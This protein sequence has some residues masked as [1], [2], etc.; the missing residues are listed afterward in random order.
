MVDALKNSMSTMTDAIIQQVFEQVKKAMEYA[1]PA[2]PLPHFDYV[3]TTGCESSRRHVPVMSHRHSEV[4]PLACRLWVWLVALGWSAVGA[5]LGRPSEQ[6]AALSLSPVGTALDRSPVGA[7]RGPQPV[8]CRRGP[9]PSACRPITERDPLMVYLIGACGPQRVVRMHGP[10]PSSCRPRGRR[11]SAGR[12]YARPAALVMSPV[13]AALGLWPV[14]TKNSCWPVATS[15]ALKGIRIAEHGPLVV[16]L[17]GVRTARGPRLVARRRGPQPVAG[18]HSSCLGPVAT[19]LAH[20]GLRIA[21]HDPLVVSPIGA[22]LCWLLVGAAPGWLYKGAARGPRPIAPRCDPRPVATSIAL[23]GLTISK[24]NPLVVSL[25]GA[26][27]SQ[28]PVGRLYVRRPST[29]HSLSWASSRLVLLRAFSPKRLR[30]SFSMVS[31]SP[32][33][34]SCMPLTMEK[35]RLIISQVH[36]MEF[37]PQMYSTFR[38]TNHPV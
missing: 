22:A 27:F 9:R 3:P 8:V 11:P 4:R 12:P 21:K 34:L 36:P 33:L 19:S 17:V 7:A 24:Q 35:G 18:R 37:S 14:A 6:P 13:S 20:K 2:R 10:R 38:L 16:S 26:P 28:S 29:Q 31:S 25:I 5:T 15:L 23:Q 1:S 32:S 30:P